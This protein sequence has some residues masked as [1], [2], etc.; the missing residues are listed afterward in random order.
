MLSIFLFVVTAT[1]EAVV[2]FA[3][4]DDKPFVGSLTMKPDVDR[5]CV[6]HDGLPTYRA[7]ICNYNHTEVWFFFQVVFFDEMPHTRAY[8]LVVG[9]SDARSERR[10]R[11][12]SLLLDADECAS[13]ALS[14][15]DDVV[16][17][18]AVCASIVS[19]SAALR[20]DLPRRYSGSYKAICRAA[21]TI[22]HR[23]SVEGIE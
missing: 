13:L 5:A 8:P 23:N 6:L 4:N 12:S 22:G 16:C 10:D 2:V 21:A 18:D 19:M 15:D 17:R 1:I 3:F 9:E 7:E 11:S 14:T 20:R